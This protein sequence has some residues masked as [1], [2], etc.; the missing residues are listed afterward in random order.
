MSAI[1]KDFDGLMVVFTAPS[2]A[3]KTTIVKEML[4]R[5]DV[6]DF[7]VS[8]TTRERRT[9]EL[10]GRDYYF[11][12]IDDFRKHLVEGELAE[13]QEV[14][15]NQ[16]Y[17]TLKSEIERIWRSNKHIIFDID[18]QGAVNLKKIYR[19][20]CLTVFVKPPSMDI[21]S[22]RLI[23]RS[24]E[25]QASLQ[26]RLSKAQAEL[27]YES[28]FD[29]VLVNEDLEL[30]LQEATLMLDTF[31]HGVERHRCSPFVDMTTISS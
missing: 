2:G 22:E 4:K 26:K 14:Y 24:T 21:L 31:V 29:F 23:Q 12:S 8:A 30:A 9:H 11:L 3:G 15:Q 19:D 1:I 27:K 7:S 18:V 13:W 16:Y 25:D 17:G 10:H 6:F 28:M 5:F 20:L